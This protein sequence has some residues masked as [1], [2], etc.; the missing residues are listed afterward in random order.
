VA[1]RIRA[2]PGRTFNGTISR[3]ARALDEATRTMLVEVDLPNDDGALLPG[4]YAEA[5]ITLQETPNAL[6]L[7]A[8]AVRFDDKGNSSVYVVDG[9][10]SVN[11]LPVATGFDDGQRIEIVSGIEPTARVVV[12]GVE[13]LQNGQQVRVQ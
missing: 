12:G 13:R 8:T 4:M 5:T 7:S 6:T 11:V 3:T 9:S 10:G 1:L 2:L